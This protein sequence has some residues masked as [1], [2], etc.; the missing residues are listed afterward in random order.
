MSNKTLY[1]SDLDGTLLRKDQTLSSYTADTVNRLVREGL[2]FSYATA[3]SYATSSLVTKGLDANFPVIVYNGTFILENGTGKKLLSHYFSIDEAREVLRILLDCGIVP[4]VYAF[5]DEKE[6]YFYCPGRINK[7]TEDFLNIRRGDGR[8]VAVDS[9]DELCQGNVFHFSCIGKEDVLR[10][11]YEKLKD[12]FSCV[13]YKEIYSGDWWLEVHPAG[14]SKAKAALELKKIMGCDR[15]VCFG[16]GKNDISIFEVADEGYAVANAEP[17]LKS[18]ATA[19][20]GGNNEDGVA[21]WLEERERH[22]GREGRDA[23]GG[24]L[25]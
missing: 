23:S 4:I 20:I 6:K 12:R 22:E 15:L 3:R 14:V 13:H 24:A 7:V 19:V 18:I 25:S 5:V 21:K 10:A 11:G 1:V 9:I 17:E 2:T 8:D 16:D